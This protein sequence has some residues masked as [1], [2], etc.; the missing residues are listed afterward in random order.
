MRKCHSFRIHRKRTTS[1]EPPPD[2]NIHEIFNSLTKFS[3]K[4]KRN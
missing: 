3:E 1:E 2:F 4:I